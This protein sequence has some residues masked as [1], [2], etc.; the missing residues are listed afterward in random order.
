MR[1]HSGR[2]S[3][4]IEAD[5]RRFQPLPGPVTPPPPRLGHAFLIGPPA[6]PL[7][8]GPPP[9]AGDIEALGHYWKRYY[10]TAEGAGNEAYFAD[11][12]RKRVKL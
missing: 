10:N 2:Q 8:P 1:E 9:P 4:D 12:Y 5:H 11:L 3:H 6:I 7:P